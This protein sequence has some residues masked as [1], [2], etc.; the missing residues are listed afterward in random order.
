MRVTKLMNSL[1]NVIEIYEYSRKKNAFEKWKF[2]NSYK[3]KQNK[4]LNKYQ[5]KKKNNNLQCYFDK[6]FEFTQKQNKK[7]EIYSIADRF[8]NH[9]V[10]I[11]AINQIHNRINMKKGIKKLK[12]VQKSRYIVFWRKYIELI[13]HRNEKLRIVLRLTNKSNL[14]QRFLKW[15]SYLNITKYHKE[16]LTEI[17]LKKDISVTKKMFLIWKDYYHYRKEKEMKYKKIDQYYKD[18]TIHYSIKKLINFRNKSKEDKQLNHDIDSYYLTRETKKAISKW[19]NYKN[20][21]ISIKLDYK[22]GVVF[23]MKRYISFWHKYSRKNNNLYYS[24]I[25]I[26]QK[27]MNKYLRKIFKYWRRYARKYKEYKAKNYNAKVYFY[28]YLAKKVFD[29]WRLV[30]IRV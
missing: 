27:H 30:N 1:N 28:S 16:K 25:T 3:I 13:K 19:M 11:K 21:Q 23:N 26:Q 14:Y 8:H 4:L 5:N 6:W 24:H 29:Q 20:T 15:K 7:R 2:F 17:H 12:K 10:M 9:Y 18:N 22:K